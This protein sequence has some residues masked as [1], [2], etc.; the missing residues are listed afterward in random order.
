[1][2]L[3][4][5]NAIITG[6][7]QGLG[8]E[9]AR[10]F[11][12][13]GANIL[14]CAR[15]GDK[16]KEAV[17]EL[18]SLLPQDTKQRIVSLKTDISDE[19]KVKELIELAIK[20]FSSLHILVNNAGVYGPKGLLEEVDSND[21]VKAININLVGPFYMMKNIL[22]H[23]KKNGY[24]KIIN[25]SGGGATAPL[26]RLSAYATSKA[27]LVRLTETISEEIRSTGIDINAIA[28]GP[29]NTRL[30]DEVLDAGP[31]KVGKTFYEKAAAQKKEGGTP[32]IK[33]AEL[34]VYL[35]SSESDGITGKLI[36]A[37]WDPWPYFKEYKADLANSDIYTLR[38]I[39]P[40]ERGKNWEEPHK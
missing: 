2:R 39:L 19:T 36:S 1:M 14:I 27:G 29:L 16:L 28:P 17:K 15:D 7:N 30:L 5:R 8:L 35:A 37:P 20:E 31:E 26:P 6:A 23:M 4:G 11:I 32:L 33:G 9:I 25:L 34:T 13:E 24:G 38:R 3:K 10:A 22:P 21:W 40:K 12:K 18:Q